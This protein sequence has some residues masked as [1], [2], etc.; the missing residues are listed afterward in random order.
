MKL[1]RRGRIFIPRRMMM[2][3]LKRKDRSQRVLFDVDYDD[4]DNE[5]LVWAK[6]EE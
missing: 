5:I 3:K 1:G 2:S 6:Q 4:S